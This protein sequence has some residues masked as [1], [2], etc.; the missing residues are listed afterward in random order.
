MAF[1]AAL[2]GDRAMKAKIE[3][4]I[5]EA[6]KEMRRALLAVGERKLEGLRAATPVKKGWLRDSERLRVM[7]SAKKEDIRISLLVG[8]E[9]AWYARI[10]ESKQKF[11]QTFILAQVGSIG[12]EIAGEFDLRRAVP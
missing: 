8:D 7:V 2:E 5:A 3:R 9:R 11:F 1:K 10:V 4:G 6:P 12:G